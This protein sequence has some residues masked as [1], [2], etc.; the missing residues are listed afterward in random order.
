MAIEKYHEKVTE[1]KQSK[2][3]IDLLTGNNIESLR[4][5]FSGLWPEP[6]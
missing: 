1:D 4:E 6:S 5:E 3:E 2:Q